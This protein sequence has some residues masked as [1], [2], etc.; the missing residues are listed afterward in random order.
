MNSC[1]CSSKNSLQDVKMI[2]MQLYRVS[3]S[4]ASSPS[5]CARLVTHRH[6]WDTQIPLM[7]ST[8][9]HMY[10]HMY[11]RRLPCCVCM[12][13]A[14]CVCTMLCVYVPC[15]VCMYHAVCVCTMLCVYVPCCVCMYHAVCV[16]TMLCVYVPCCVCM[17]HA[18]CVCTMLCVYVPCCVCMYHAVCVCTMLCVYVPCCVCMY[19]HPYGLTEPTTTLRGSCQPLPPRHAVTGPPHLLTQLYNSSPP[20]TLWTRVL[21]KGHMA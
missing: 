7:Y 13:H 5:F 4:H 3:R 20:K 12:Y 6:I 14:V 18:V 15:C 8:Y 9:I 10:V 16:C 17:Y 19:M 1:V 2:H 21:Q 11:R